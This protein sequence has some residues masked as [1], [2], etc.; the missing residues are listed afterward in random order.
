MRLN[1]L[2]GNWGEDIAKKYLI[3]KGYTIISCNIKLGYGELDIV[4][5]LKSLLVFVEV[6][7]KTMNNYGLAV[8]MVNAK[9]IKNMKST[10]MKYLSKY[11]LRCSKIRFDVIT[12][13]VDRI[14]KT[15]KLCHY[16]DII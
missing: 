14:N 12:L 2:I 8:E 10:A 4:A 6:K 3:R 5:R 15:A 1:K 11:S 9:K 13:D 16:K 7:T